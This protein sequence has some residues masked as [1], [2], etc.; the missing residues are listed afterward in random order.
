MTPHFA[1]VMGIR[2]TL[3]WVNNE[4]NRRDCGKDS[5]MLVKWIR[6]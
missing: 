6:S 1:E 2:D 5:L 3:G 4:A